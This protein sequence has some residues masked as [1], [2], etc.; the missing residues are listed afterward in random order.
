MKVAVIGSCLSN[1][2]AVFMAR[3]FGWMRLNNAATQRS[4]LFL[5]HVVEGVGPPPVEDVRS[6]FGLPG[7][8]HPLDRYLLENYRH[9]CGLTEMPLGAAPLW[10]NLHDEQFDLILLDNLADIVY[11]KA[12]YK[13][14]EFPPFELAFEVSQTPR[15]SEL[16]GQFEFLPELTAQQSA[17]NWV[18]ILRFVKNL[19]PQARL[20]FS[21][22]PYC[23]AIGDPGRYDRAIAFHNLFVERATAMGVEVLPPPD[24]PLA[25][26]K[27]PD[28]RDHFDLSVYQAIAGHLHMSVVGGWKNWTNALLPR[29]LVEADVDHSSTPSAAT[30]VAAVA[31]SIELRSVVA[32]SLGVAIDKVGE[33]AAMSRTEKWDS[34][35]QIGVVLA[36]EDAF[37]VKLPF[38]ATTNAASVVSLRRFLMAVGVRAGD[39][40]DPERTEAA[41][42]VPG[43]AN[44][45]D[46]V[47][48]ATLGNERHIVAPVD[49]SAADPQRHI[50]ADFVQRALM[51]PDEPYMLFV[52][53][54]ARCVLSH[55][56]ILARATAVAERLSHLA[57]GAVVALV[58]DHSPALYSGFVGC[59]LAGLTPTI[60]SPRTSRQDPEVFLDSMAALFERIAPAAVLTAGVAAHSVPDGV[61]DLV[62]LDRLVTPDD[63]SVR[64]AAAAF[65]VQVESGAVAF[66]QHSSGTTGRKK[67]VVLTHA[68]VLDH[69]RR[70][71]GVVGVEAGDRIA[72]WLPLYHDMGLITSFVLPTILGCPIIS[73]DAQEWV[74]KPGVLLDLIEDEQAQFCWMPNFAFQHV[75]R[76][77]QSGLRNLRSMRMFINCSEPCRAAAFDVFLE[78]YAAAGV[79]PESLQVSYAMAENVFAVT[80]TVPGRPTPRRRISE[81][82]YLSS[83]RPL[84][85][86]EI[87]IRDVDGW[88][89]ATGQPG[90]IWLRSNCLFSGYHLRPDLTAGRLIDGW[91]RTGDL[92]HLVDGELYVV[93]RSDDMVIVNGRNIVAHEVEDQIGQL[94]GVAPGRVLVAGDFDEA[95]GSRG[96]IVL[97]ELRPGDGAGEAAWES[98]VRDLVFASTGVAPSLVRFVPR[99]FLVKSSSGKLSREASL[100]KWR[101]VGISF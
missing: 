89:L 83:G 2:P 40:I 10:R 30:A 58:L 18:A 77:D 27:L 92:G 73:L 53:G 1:L 60:L 14:T 93:G 84:P 74:S 16:V 98:S 61:F 5:K 38:E 66:L 24:I 22:A 75:A 50:F 44:S 46:G 52:A 63:L 19:Q 70:Y 94:D 69:V 86:V 36:V 54:D 31:S 42:P 62:D 41:A 29:N 21:S 39:H 3:D 51:G 4:D 79:R 12:A 26:T 6:L 45:G 99:G 78:R 11:G 7:E 32:A 81:V 48:R 68:Q 47:V 90:E 67:G 34:L 71:A 43:R 100:N 37:G 15:A 8:S 91:W 9:H 35:K 55:G 64:A 33:D 96:L 85:G 23:T 13:G 95:T 25:L 88:P 17:D 49:W 20:V 82:E 72:S 28:D 65:P 101:N 57:P 76:N 80:Q 97:A 87:E 56:E 59:V